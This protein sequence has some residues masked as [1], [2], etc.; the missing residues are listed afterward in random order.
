M[1]REFI[2]TV[3]AAYQEADPERRTIFVS[4]HLIAAFEGLIDECTIIDA[5]REVLRLEADHA[6]ARYQRIRARFAGE[7]PALRMPGVLHSR[8]DG[9]ELEIT[10][11]GESAAI[12]G[13]LKTFSPEAL[14]TEALT[15]EEIFVATLK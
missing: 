8:R 14:T 11:N 10:A 12:I 1:R 9:R 13:R 4:T 2:Q 6:R 15:L 5:G 7:P 3:I